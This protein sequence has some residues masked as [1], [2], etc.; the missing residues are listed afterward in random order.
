[1]IGWRVNYSFYN[2]NFYAPTYKSINITALQTLIPS[3]ILTSG[4]IVNMRKG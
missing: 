3:P 2:T 4:S 1:M